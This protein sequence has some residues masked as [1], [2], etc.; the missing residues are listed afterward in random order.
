MAHSIAGGTGS[1]M[2]SYLL[3]MLADKYG[4]KLIQTYRCDDAVACDWWCV[5]MSMG[6]SKYALKYEHGCE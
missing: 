3:E 1:G 6:V 5:S 4:K 2:G